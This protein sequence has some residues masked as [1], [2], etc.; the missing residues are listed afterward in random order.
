M[1]NRHAAQAVEVYMW[2]RLSIRTATAHHTQSQPYDIHAGETHTQ[3]IAVL[4]GSPALALGRTS[5]KH[6]CHVRVY[7]ICM[8]RIRGPCCTYLDTSAAIINPTLRYMS[9]CRQPVPLPIIILDDFLSS[10]VCCTS[11]ARRLHLGGPGRL[12]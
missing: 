6:A 2:S 10:A 1:N 7:L 5:Q 12:R 11:Y 9:I 8:Q 3:T 4:P